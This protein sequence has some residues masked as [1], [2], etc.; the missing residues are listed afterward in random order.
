M[1]RAAEE[2]N[3]TYS[4]VNYVREVCDFSIFLTSPNSV[5]SNNIKAVFLET[6]GYTHKSLSM[7]HRLLEMLKV[8]MCEIDEEI[9]LVSANLRNRFFA[10]IKI[11]LSEE[12][13]LSREHG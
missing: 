6:A 1:L 10:G 3:P 11:N 13:V 12:V 8:H 9:Q 2:F 4:N 7:H 5:P